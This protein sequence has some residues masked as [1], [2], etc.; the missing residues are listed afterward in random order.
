MANIHS[1]NEADKTR[2]VVCK[3]INYMEVKNAV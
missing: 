1:N 3:A 2:T